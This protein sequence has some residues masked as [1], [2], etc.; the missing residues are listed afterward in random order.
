[1]PLP[2]IHL[3][4]PQVDRRKAA[5]YLNS[6]QF[7][8]M[9]E[10][11]INCSW[12]RW[13][14]EAGDMFAEE[15]AARPKQVRLR[16]GGT[17]HTV[18]SSEDEAAALR[19]LADGDL[20]VALFPNE[21]GW[22][23]LALGTDEGGGFLMAVPTQA[24]AGGLFAQEAS[25]HLCNISEIAK[26]FRSGRRVIGHEMKAVWKLL[27]PYG[28]RFDGLVFDTQVAEFCL[29]G[30]IA[31]P[32]LAM[33][34]QRLLDR[35]RDPVQPPET[36]QILLQL[37]PKLEEELKRDG[38][39]ELFTQMEAPLVPILA[40]MET[41]GVRVDTQ[42]FAQFSQRLAEE[43][44]Q[45]EQEVFRLA[46]EEFSIGSTKQLQVILYEKMGVTKGR[47]TKTGF[48][49]DAQHLEPLREEFPIVDKI[50][51]WREMSKLKSTYVDALPQLIDLKTGRIHTTF[52]QCV[53]ATGRLSSADPNLQNIPI[54]T[55]L[56]RS[57]RTAFV[58]SQGNV[59]ISCDYSQIEL[60]CLAHLAHDPGLIEA[61][62]TGLDIHT[63]TAM[64]IFGL[65]REEVTS[66]HRRRAK[67]INF[68][69]LYGMGERRVSR[70]FGVSAEEARGFI[71]RYFE[72]FPNVKKWMDETL[73]FCRGSGYVSTLYGRRRYIPDILH[74][75][76]QLRAFAERMAINAPI[77]G[78]ASDVMKLGMVAVARALEREKLKAQMILQVHDEL[79][80]DCPLSEADAVEALV[81]REMAGAASLKVPLEVDSKRG[82][83]WGEC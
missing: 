43:I 65:T 83:N 81:R 37:A 29:N 73:E 49:T 7:R 18:A 57:I 16:D 39:W 1:M 15:A 2:E 79:L 68:G 44:A 14:G 36:P 35:P 56:G 82:A 70:E 10:R 50:L 33:I 8:G 12:F 78:T 51:Q 38:M 55:E 71:Q 76:Q 74:S 61:F 22:I 6:L 27:A 60:R 31:S 58:P 52:N 62:A 26:L 3:E 13:V 9:A 20:A 24:E 19:A 77:Q 4:P 17:G 72:G 75:N 67:V 23:D 46:G 40:Q 53:A 11:V 21:G 41:A 45:L 32:G 42:N 48:S 59:L 64:E 80:L 5:A 63:R 47:K 34:A 54:R 30:L 66:E 28:A 69:L 25:R